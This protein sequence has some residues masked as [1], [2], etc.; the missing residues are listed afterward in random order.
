MRFSTSYCRPCL[1]GF[2]TESIIALSQ[3][4]GNAPDHSH[5]PDRAFQVPGR[6][7]ERDIFYITKEDLI[8]TGSTAYVER[9][10]S[11]HVAKTV[12]PDPFHPRAELR[13]R[14]DMA[15]EASIYNMMRDSSF[16]P[17]LIDWDPEACVLTLQDCP[18]GDLLSYI[19]GSPYVPVSASASA[20]DYNNRISLSTRQK[21]L[22]QA[23]K[24]LAALHTAVTTHNDI[25]PRNF[26]VDEAL[27]INIC[28]FAGCSL[29]C[30]QAP[31]CAPGPR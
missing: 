4:H 23:A 1:L 12:L 14:Q 11:G 13:H 27:D 17:K 22:L 10:P 16:V 29:G 30:G 26:L 5:W 24:A 15:R 18:N 8:G 21:W 9:L 6:R 19:R 2:Q 31:P 7:E 20:T 28:D 25:A 3:A